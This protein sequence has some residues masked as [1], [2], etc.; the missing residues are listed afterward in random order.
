M[1]ISSEVHFHITSMSN[2]GSICFSVVCLKT[3]LKI[4]KLTIFQIHMHYLFEHNIKT[5]LGADLL[6]GATSS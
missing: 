6:R 3:E 4:L 2:Q 1:Y 5:E